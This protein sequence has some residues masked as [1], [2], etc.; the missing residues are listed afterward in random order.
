M[1]QIVAGGSC[2]FQRGELQNR[3]SMEWKA[4]TSRQ[5]NVLNMCCP[6]EN[7]ILGQANILQ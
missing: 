2:L 5:M 7:D 1:K 6:E 3:K 4:E